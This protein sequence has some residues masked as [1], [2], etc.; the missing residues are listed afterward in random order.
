[1]ISL[2]IYLDFPFCI[3]RCAFCSFNIQGYRASWGERYLAALDREIDL[4]PSS[5]AT[6]TSLYLGGGTP[7]IHP[8]DALARVIA[9]CRRKWSVS[10]SAEITIEAHPA[11]VTQAAA[12]AWRAAGINRLSIGVQS[13]SDAVLLRLG[14]HHT[15]AEAQSAVAI[16]RAAGFD[17]VGIDLIFAL[18]DQALADWAATLDAAC[19]LAPDHLSVY[20]L[21]VD[22]GTLFHKTGVTAVS[23]ADAAAQYRLTQTRLATAGYAQYEISNFARPG[24]ACR[25]N[26]RYWDRADVLGI[27]LSAASYRNEKTGGAHWENTA[28]MDDYLARIALDQLPIDV[29]EWIDETTAHKER[30]IFGL[31]KSGGIPLRWMMADADTRQAMNRLVDCGW[32]Q[33]AGEMVRLTLDGMLFAD[34]VAAALI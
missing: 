32:I 28:N 8:P 11:T 26:L 33:V 22:A 1:M 17:S 15:A 4:L 31:R 24:F 5:N 12:D 10:S 7:T 13:L 6:V 2:G 9:H 25:H 23:D 34:S 30:L 18:P 16:G 14:R 19:A 29:N 21:S 20:A 3:A 27:G